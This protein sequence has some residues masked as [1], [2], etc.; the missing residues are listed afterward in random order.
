VGEQSREA[1]ARLSSPA[2]AA[3][4]WGLAEGGTTQPVQSPL[5]WHV[6]KVDRVNRTGA[7]P[8][9]AARAELVA[10]INARKTQEASTTAVTRVEEALSDGASLDEVARAQGLQ[11]VETPPLLPNGQSPDNAAWQAGPDVQPLLRAASDLTTEDDPVVETVAPNRF[12]VLSVSRVIPAAAPPLAQVRDRVRADLIRERALARGRTIADGIVAKI[13]R[14]VAPRDA[15]A[16]AGVPLPALQPISARRIDIARPGQPV[17]PPLTMMFSLPQ[18]RARALA[19]PDGQGWFV[20]HTATTTPGS[21]AG[22][23]QL[24]QATRTQFREALGQE[25]ADQFTRAVQARA[26]IE[27]KPD[28]LAA[29]KRRIQQGGAVAP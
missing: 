2:V 15:F 1:F 27:R 23:T 22:Q 28:A 25:Y 13:N 5:G 14:G 3:A 6:V 18:G 17:P 20:V 8:L 19:A 26:K 4:A 16:Q 7:I 29:V 12:A 21:A 11:V 24:I 9:A 10:E